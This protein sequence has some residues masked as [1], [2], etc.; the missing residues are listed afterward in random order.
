[1]WHA[2]RQAQTDT[3]RDSNGFI[4]EPQAAVGYR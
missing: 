4:I 3:D 1:M 2:Y